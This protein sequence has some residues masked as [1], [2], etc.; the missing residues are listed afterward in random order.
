MFR[1]ESLTGAGPSP[2]AW[3]F[4]PTEA[5]TVTA[6]LDPKF[7]YQERRCRGLYFEILGRE[8]GRRLWTEQPAGG[9]WQFSSRSLQLLQQ[10]GSPLQQ[11]GSHTQYF[12]TTALGFPFRHLPLFHHS[13]SAVS[14]SSHPNYKTLNCLGFSTPW[15]LFQSHPFPHKIISWIH[16]LLSSNPYWTPS[17]PPIILNEEIGQSSASVTLM[18]E[19]TKIAWVTVSGHWVRRVSDLHLFWLLQ[20]GQ[21]ETV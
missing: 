20:L 2:V 1:D 8:P 11:W 17:L 7:I 19:M 5:A 9:S 14:P 15:S 12:K 3:P 18:K 16:L 4:S 13:L 6:L 21:R 10:W